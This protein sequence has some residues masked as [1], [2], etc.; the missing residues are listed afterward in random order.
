MKNGLLKKG[1]RTLLLIKLPQSHFHTVSLGPWGPRL[2]L[3]PGRCSVGNPLLLLH[4]FSP[5][6]QFFALDV[7]NSDGTPLTCDQLCVQLER[8]CSFSLQTDTEPVGIL[9]TQHRDIWTKAY[10]NLIKGEHRSV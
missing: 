2:S 1:H 4:V 9:T 6:I 7:Y 5:W 3:A 8:I 10:I